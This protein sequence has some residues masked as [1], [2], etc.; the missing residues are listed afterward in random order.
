LS[1]R[2]ASLLA[3]QFDNP[4]SELTLSPQSGTM[5]FTTDVGGGGLKQFLKEQRIAWFSKFF[6]FPDMFVNKI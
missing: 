4:M 2:S 6:L 3:G 1:Y 5:N